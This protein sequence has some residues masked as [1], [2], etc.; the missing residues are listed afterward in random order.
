MKKSRIIEALASMMIGT[1]LVPDGLPVPLIS[2]EAASASFKDVPDSYYAKEEIA[3][4]MEK[5]MI[6]GFTD[7]TFRPS[8]EVTR[9]EFAAFVARSL[10]L[11]EA[12]SKFKDVSK[13][14]ALYDGVSRANK[15]GIIKGFSNGTFKP[16]V[17]VTREDMAV[18]LNRA[19]QLKGS[20]TK[21]KKL[22]FSDTK[23]I[24]AYAQTSVQRLYYYNVMGA[25]SG[26][27][28]SGQ[29]VGNRAETAV[30]IY[31]MLQVLNGE[32]L[33]APTPP[34]TTTTPINTPIPEN[35]KLGDEIYVKGIHFTYS[36]LGT[37]DTDY[38]MAFS[39]ERLKKQSG[40]E[41]QKGVRYNFRNVAAKYE[42][43]LLI[44]YL[45]WE[46]APFNKEEFMKI[47][48]QVR[49]TKKPVTAKGFYFY[50]DPK[51]T[52]TGDIIFELK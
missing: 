2:A 45:I 24:S 13:S 18:M 52:N 15:A 26:K 17:K 48:N 36:V 7:G 10:N 40:S 31:R 42:E 1:A 41:F 27:N 50:L 5:G 25:Y 23:S 14:M 6:N 44:S 11:P 4:L 37:W 8:Q 33:P 30:S 29:T 20:F 38:G 22:D 47:V 32:A 9:A 19:M 49:N 46:D 34:P 12:D 3:A 21:T 28:F 43:D 39:K 51:P 16:N 35:P